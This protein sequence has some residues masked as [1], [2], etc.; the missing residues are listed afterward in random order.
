MSKVIHATEENFESIVL[1]SKIPVVVDFWATWCGPCKMIAPM[2]DEV[3]VSKEDV[4]IVKVDVDKNK[5]LSA[6]YNIR[7]IPTMNLFIDGK[8]QASKMGAV[9]KAAFMSWLD[10]NI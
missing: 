2:L 10:M 7:S 6:K 3:S 4:L 5:N 8:V 9:S 1:K